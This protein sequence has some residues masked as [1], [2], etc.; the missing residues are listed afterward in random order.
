MLQAFLVV[1][2]F[3]LVYLLA[4]KPKLGRR[5]LQLV[6]ALG[7]LVVSAGWW[8]AVVSLWP[9]SSRPFVGSTTDNSVVSLM[10]GYNGL[11]RLF[12]GSGSAGGGGGGGA[13]FGGSSGWTRLFNTANGGQISWLLPLAGAGLLA[14][15]WLSRRGRRTDTDRAGWL[16]WGLWALTCLAIFSLSQGTFHPYYNVQLAPA[17]AALAGAGAV[18][19]WQLGRTRRWL[20]WLLP[21]A[22]LGTGWWAVQLLDRTSTYHATLRSAILPIAAVAAVTLLA[23]S[24]V[25]RRWLLIGAG[26]VASVAVLAGPAAYSVTTVLHPVSG[27][28]VAAGPAVAGG[29]MGGGT[30]RSGAPSGA[31]PTG[32]TRTAPS[33]APPSGTAPTGNAAGGPGTSTTVDSELVQYLLANRGSATYLVAASGSQSS[34]SIILATG[35]PVI[36]IG[37]FTGSDPA[38]TLEQFKQLVAEGKVRFLLA[39]GQGGGGGGQGASSSISSWAAQVGTTV[40]VG[41]TTLYDLS[42]VTASS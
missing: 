6:A 33:G 15:L 28:L 1:P 14:G 36:T 17:V 9:A 4:G 38:P 32:T 20:A 10:L 27:S 7:A 13:G 30:A 24:L 11:S 12:G 39:G 19:L 41:S 23:A 35:Q 40:T 16:L 37:G 42:G 5:L 31:A 26:A 8:T 22:V 2:A 21:A 18:S 25:R 3:V 29:G 34:A